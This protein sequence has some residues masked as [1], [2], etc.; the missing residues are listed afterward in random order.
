[1]KHKQIIIFLLFFALLM[2]VFVSAQTE[3]I[4]KAGTFFYLIDTTLEKVGLFFTFSPEKKAQKA[5]EYADK[6][7]L[8]IQALEESD[9]PDAVETLVKNYENNIALAVQKSKEVTDKEKAE[10]LLNSVADN[11]SKNQEVL[12]AVLLKV[13]DEAKEAIARAIETS[14]KNNEEALKQITDLRK[15][16]SELKDEVQ[17]LKEELKTKD[18]QQKKTIEELSK[19]KSESAQVPA[20]AQ[21]KSTSS[22]TSET[23]PIPKQATTNI[24]TLPNGAVVEMDNGGNILRYLK[25]PQVNVSTEN[26]P[27]LL[28][29]TG[30]KA[31]T[32]ETSVKIEW[33]TNKP[34]ES[35]V[36][37]SGSELPLKIFKSESGLSTRHIVDASLPSCQGVYEFEIEVV[38]NNTESQK[39]TSRFS[40]EGLNIRPCKDVPE[41]SIINIKKTTVAALELSPN[42]DCAKLFLN[43]T[44]E[45]RNCWHYRTYKSG[46]QWNIVDDISKGT[47]ISINRTILASFTLN[48]KSSCSELYSIGKI[49]WRDCLLYRAYKDDYK[50]NII[51]NVGN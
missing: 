21:I 28:L 3:N 11:T 10:N 51:E 31:I 6:R 16:V 2:P 1:M 4:P 23:T 12:S 8:Q 35:R 37:I 15:E 22:Q 9:T 38:F 36:F 5:L 30:V 19:Q 39:L 25:E 26:T 42:L 43:G 41:G 45:W 44:I 47:V 32:H 27:E 7:L 49:D 50:W 34:T 48:P 29:I 17:K 18:E 40:V 20:P 24:V 33:Q 14:R 46:Y 13:P